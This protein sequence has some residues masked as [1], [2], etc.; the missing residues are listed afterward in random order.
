MVRVHEGRGKPR[1]PA[2]KARQAGP[3]EIRD[4]TT[5][6]LPS[7]DASQRGNDPDML[8]K[9]AGFRE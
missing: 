9:I 6:D 5:P 8:V 1:S 7:R 2:R 4:C 3:T